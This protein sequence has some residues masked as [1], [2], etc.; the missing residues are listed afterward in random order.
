MRN[1]KEDGTLGYKIIAV[2]L[3]V[4]LWIVV[5][6][7]SDYQTTKQIHEIPVTQINGAVLEELDQIY[8]VVSGDTVD[9]I[10]K[11]RRSVI[12]TLD[13]SDFKAV[14]DLSTMS[15]TNSVQIEVTANSDTVAAEIDITCL[16]NTMKLNL[17]KKVAKQYPI[18]VLTQGELKNGFAVG[19]TTVSPGVITVEGPK[20]AVDRITEVV[21]TADVSGKYDDFNTQAPIQ[22]LDAYGEEIQ[23]DKISISQKLVS[24]NV[25]VYPTKTVDLVVEL[26]GNP[27]DGYA[28]E[29]IVYQPEEIVVAGPSDLI[30]QVDEVVIRD[31]SI[32]GL[33]ED[34]QTTVDLKGYV[35]DGLIVA[36]SNTEMV[37]TV[38]ISKTVEKTLKPSEK[39]IVLNN[40]QDNL[41]YHITVSED[42]AITMKGFADQVNELTID[43]VLPTIDCSNLP[44]GNHNNVTV[45]TKEIDGVEY[46][47]TG[48]VSVSVVEK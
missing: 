3:A 29:S 44:M 45:K 36:Q 27:G 34:Y 47:I 22:L 18:R 4:L 13:A 14:A 5:A 31:I 37:L 25:S 17:E 24:A 38:T 11:G 7:I 19:E 28:V 43:D 39:S 9:I 16:D 20:S 1:K 41:D 46:E 12:G 15:I 21:V 10:V 48:T 40:K 30:S 6:N 35:G 8:D 42:Y 2:V 32:S 23:N 26:R 33:T